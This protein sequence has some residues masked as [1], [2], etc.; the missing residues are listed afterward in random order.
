MTN[1][2]TSILKL[3]EIIL[4]FKKFEYTESALILKLKNK[5]L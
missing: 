3:F 1:I 4:S 2:F 5:N